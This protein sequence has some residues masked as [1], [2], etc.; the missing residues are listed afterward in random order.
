MI[1]K[2]LD[3]Q[4]SITIL[5]VETAGMENHYVAVLIE[6]MLSV[7]LIM[8]LIRKR[9]A[10]K[11]KTAGVMQRAEMFYYIGTPQLKELTPSGTKYSY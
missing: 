8:G 10:V 9:R 6:T 3:A 5:I 1:L 11:L 2:L 7:L 4:L